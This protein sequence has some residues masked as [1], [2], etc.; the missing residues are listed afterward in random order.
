MRAWILIATL[1][2]CTA[3]GSS[4][5]ERDQ[6]RLSGDLAGR[7][8]GEAQ[9]CLAHA[10][11]QS[12][13]PID[14]RTLISD[15]GRTIWVNRLRADCPGLRPTSALIIEPVGDRYCAGDRIRALEPGMTIPGPI[16]VLGDW[17]PYRA[18]D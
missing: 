3:T 4:L 13:T 10:G 7:T 5:E 18:R 8:A 11:T 2:G 14:R 6:A 9:S 15:R 1:A 12:L 17:T 16:C